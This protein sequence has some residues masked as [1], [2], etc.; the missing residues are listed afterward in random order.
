MAAFPAN[1]LPKQR[2]LVIIPPTKALP[3]QAL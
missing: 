3:K 2:K 1:S